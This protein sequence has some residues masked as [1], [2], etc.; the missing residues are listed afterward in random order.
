MKRAFGKED[1]N[2]VIVDIGG[3][4]IRIGYLC[5][6]KRPSICIKTPKERA[7]FLELLTQILHEIRTK[8][9]KENFFIIVGCPGL[10]DKDGVIQKTLYLDIEGVN[11]RSMLQKKVQCSVLV[12]NDANLQSLAF[13]N[14]YQNYLYIVAGTGVGGALISNGELHLGAHGFAGEIGHMPLTDN[15][16]VCKCSQIGCLDS[17]ASGYYLEKVLGKRWWKSELTSK[18]LGVI[19]LAGSSTGKA[20]VLASTLFDP[21]KIIVSGH[22]V[23]YKGFTNNLIQ[24]LKNSFPKKEVIFERNTW[25][26]V[27][28]GVRS[29]IKKI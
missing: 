24:E 4:N 14:K 9:H 23:S 3:S 12:L 15:D 16:S 8:A 1:R 10:I 7:L 11:L 22:L 29:L 27:V 18:E 13:L 6:D 21:E 28:K 20:V 26:L 25:P 2:I 17:V 19:S 5:D